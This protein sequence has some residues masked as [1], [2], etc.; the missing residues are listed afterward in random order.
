MTEKSRLFDNKRLEITINRLC[1]QLIENH[2]NFDDTILVGLQPRGIYFLNRIKK[3]LENLLN[4][5]IHIGYLDTT[6]Y[7][8]DFRSKE[9]PKAKDTLMPFLVDDKNVVIIDDVLFTGRT[10]RSAMEGI[11]N[12]GRPNKIE[13]LVLIDRKY[14]RDVP[15]EPTYYGIKINTITSDRIEVNLREQGFKE[16]NIMIKNIQNE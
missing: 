15:I 3:K 7:R 14:S 10:V 2:K 12:F 5:G 16:D 4:K 9:V 13:L 1:Q 8:D 11:M 6:F